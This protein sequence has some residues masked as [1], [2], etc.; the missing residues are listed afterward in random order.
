MNDLLLTQEELLDLF[1]KD[2]EEQTARFE[3]AKNLNKINISVYDGIIKKNNSV[4]L[5]NRVVTC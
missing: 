5:K 3:A 4:I 2:F 1:Q